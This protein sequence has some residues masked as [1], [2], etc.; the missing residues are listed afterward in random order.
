MI[1][2][3]LGKVIS[4]TLQ[5]DDFS[6]TEEMKAS[7]VPGWDSLTHVSVILSVEKEFGVRFSDS[8]IIRLK[9]IGDLQKLVDSKMK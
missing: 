7:D 3:R 9:N 8:E 2:E 6:L 5:L 4:K 1:S